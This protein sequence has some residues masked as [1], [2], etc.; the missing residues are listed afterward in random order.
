MAQWKKRSRAASVVIFSLPMVGLLLLAGCTVQPAAPSSEQ[1]QQ[2]AAQDAQQARRDLKDAGRETQQ[3][4]KEAR[5]ET[6]AAVAGAREGWQ[7]G[8]PNGPSRENSDSS[9]VDLNHASAAE[10]KTLP[11]VNSAT[12]REIIDGRPY[13]RASQIRKRGLVSRDEYARIAARLT[14]TP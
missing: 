4:L 3:A 12:A 5:R 2:Q 8:A 1:I 10:L 7:A 6:Q 9:S 11:G 14:V 13:A